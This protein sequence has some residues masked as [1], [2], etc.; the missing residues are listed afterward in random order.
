MGNSE[1]H[2]GACLGRYTFLEVLG[3]GDFRGVPIN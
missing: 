1:P 3:R 2:V